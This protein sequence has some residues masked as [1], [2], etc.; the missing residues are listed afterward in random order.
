MKLQVSYLISAVDPSKKCSDP[1]YLR[2]FLDDNKKVPHIIIERTEVDELSILKELHSKYLKCDF[3]FYPIS[4]TGFRFLDSETCE[5]CYNVTL[6][7]FS[8]V[9]V[10]GKWYTLSEIQ[11]NKILLEEYHGELYFKS[12][13][14]F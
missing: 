8:N 5:V 7:Y 10:G 11:N 9:A 6:R 4:L 2:I 1:D 12:R 13:G 14:I 3:S